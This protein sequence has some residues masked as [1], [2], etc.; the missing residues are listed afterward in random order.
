ME[1]ISTVIAAVEGCGDGYRWI[2]FGEEGCVYGQY[3][4]YDSKES[5]WVDRGERFGGFPVDSIRH[6]STSLEMVAENEK[7]VFA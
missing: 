3:Q 4:E 6:V 7:K 5:K 2:F 1:F